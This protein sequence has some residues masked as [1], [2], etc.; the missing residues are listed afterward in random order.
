MSDEEIIEAIESRYEI[1]S[2][3]RIGNL[4]L[5]WHETRKGITD[6]TIYRRFEGSGLL[7][8]GYGYVSDRGMYFI[9]LRIEQ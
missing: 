5:S 2:I 3:E 7:P 9:R 1:V 8:T 4:I 6:Q